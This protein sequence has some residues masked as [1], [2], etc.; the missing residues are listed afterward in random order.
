VLRRG[1]RQ[2]LLGVLV[3]VCSGFGAIVFRYLILGIE[4]ISFNRLGSLLG[5]LGDK[6]VIL[7]PAL[8]G[9]LVGPLVYFFA[10]E[11]KGHGVPEVMESVA[12]KGGKIRPRVAV[13]KSLASSIC[14]GTGGSVGREGPIVQ[15]GSALGSAFGSVLKLSEEERKNLV[16][17]GAAG[18]I[19]ATFNA[20]IAGVLFAL[21]VILRDFSTGR[22]G[23]VVISSVTASAIGRAFLGNI[24]AFEVP[25]YSLVS[26]WELLLYAVL[27]VIAGLVSVAF[28]RSIYWSEDRFDS[29]S[30]PPYLKAAVGGIGV[31]VIGYF[32]PQVFGVGYDTI[33]DVLLNKAPLVM[34]I[35]LIP[36][37]VV[38]TSLTLGSGGSGGIFSPS[39]FLGSV[40]GGSYGRLAGHLFPG[41]AGTPG[42]YAL[43]SMA[44]VFAGAARAPISSIVFLY[45]LTWDYRIILPLMLCTVVSTLFAEKL[46]KESIYTLKLVRRGVRLSE[47]MAVDLLEGLRVSD[48]LHPVS[49]TI[50]ADAEIGHILRKISDSPDVFYPVL[51]AHGQYVGAIYL[52]DLPTAMAQTEELSHLLIAGDLAGVP[53]TVKPSDTLKTALERL[54]Q[55]SVDAVPVLSEDDP[56]TV[57]GSLRRR[58]VVHAYNKEL[59]KRKG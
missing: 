19:A 51:D 54:V 24:P 47:S 41:I 29:W 9:L 39:L 40:V 48:I 18:G 6:Y 7:L 31:G 52:E 55:G 59:A 58:D 45:E 57:V 38:A 23:A 30:F 26:P 2:I 49:Q 11:A 46:S 32:L 17:C 43:V 33:S 42:G 50:P 1:L 22:F 37:K 3:G 10:R 28:T 8:G 56:H 53:P 4:D 34:M 27:G 14:I 12:L 15:I 44:A 20:P 13:V 35:I 36:A 25:A 21:E 5:F 16:A